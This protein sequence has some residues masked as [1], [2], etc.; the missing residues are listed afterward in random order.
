MRSYLCQVASFTN[1][2]EAECARCKLESEGIV[3][4]LSNV[5]LVLWFWYY[6]L[7]TGGVRVLVRRDDLDD[8]R[9]VLSWREPSPTTD[10]EPCAHCGEVIV[11]AW[12]ICWRCGWSADDTGEP[13]GRQR[14]APGL[15]CERKTA[16]SDVADDSLSGPAHG[17]APPL[18][19]AAIALAVIA[20]ILVWTRT[21]DW[22]F[23]LAGWLVAL[24]A[25]ELLGRILG[26][27]GEPDE[28]AI[29][30]ELGAEPEP[31]L[32]PAQQSLLRRREAGSRAVGR[33][34]RAAVFALYFP[35]L[36]LC[37]VAVF[38]RVGPRRMNL[39]RM[40]CLR[41]YGAWALSLLVA[42]ECSAF[43]C[44]LPCL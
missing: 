30:H 7:V 39:G 17:E 40:D 18:S 13:D 37:S 21:G 41:Y 24:L 19:I 14:P 35:P 27:Q 16:D 32:T 4:R 9:E 15:S 2:A 6:S 25:A 31:V 44:G 8:A 43:V 36:A 10:Q 23:G 34:W 28:L 29:E 1:V 12:D 20:G 33:A 11:D 5:N 26:G 22:L 42:M 38:C 3:A